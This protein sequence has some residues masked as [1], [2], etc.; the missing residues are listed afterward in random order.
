MTVLKRGDQ[1]KDVST[2]QQAL[3]TLM[4]YKIAVDGDFGKQTELAVKYFQREH[5]LKDTGV[6]D[7][8]TQAKINEALV[9]SD[10]SLFGNLGIPSFNVNS[11]RNV[12][13]ELEVMIDTILVQHMPQEFKI[14]CDSKDANKLVWMAN[15]ALE[16]RKVREL[17]NN[18]DGHDVVL[19]QETIGGAENEAWCMGEQQSCVGYSERKTGIKSKLYPSESCMTVATESPQSMVVDIRDCQLGDI[20]IWQH[21]TSWKGHTGN[22]ERWILNNR[23]A[24]LIEGNTTSGKVGEAIVREGGGTYTTERSVG[25]IG[26]MTLKC[27]IRAF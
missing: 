7:V 6:A 24:R 22:F 4:Y 16:I 18:N 1:G 9:H 26:D 27:V 25:R 2:L 17:T 14:A 11:K 8:V 13:R 21:G 19:I 10:S 23:I 12:E 15:K 5:N 3:A 20:W